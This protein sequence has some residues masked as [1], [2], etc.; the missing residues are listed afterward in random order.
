MKVF[1]AEIDIQ[2]DGFGEDFTI[3]MGK[4][5]TQRLPAL[6][7]SRFKEIF[8]KVEGRPFSDIS[9]LASDGN[10]SDQVTREQ[11]SITEEESFQIY[12][13][14]LIVAAISSSPESSPNTVLYNLGIRGAALYNLAALEKNCEL[15]LFNFQ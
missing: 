14:G 10:M 2:A 8:S 13:L 6:T 9:M 15:S 11:L 1:K 7:G 12:L 5:D 4:V 3:S